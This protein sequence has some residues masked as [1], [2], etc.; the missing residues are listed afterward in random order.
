M[1]QV[2]QMPASKLF[3]QVRSW[4]LSAFRAGGAELNM[5]S[6]MLAAFLDA[7]LPRPTM[8]SASRVESGPDSQAYSYMAHTLRSLLPLL[9]RAGCATSEEVAIDTLAE[10]LRQDAVT[11]E[12]ASFLPRMV[13]AWTRLP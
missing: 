12:R 9:E 11:T 10:R 4:I 2:S 8:I 1:E 7:G 3:N 13:G 5:G 6:K